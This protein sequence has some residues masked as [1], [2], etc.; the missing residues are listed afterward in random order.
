VIYFKVHVY[1]AHRQV[2]THSTSIYPI[3]DP[4]LM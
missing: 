1:R 3:Y 2:R 4:I